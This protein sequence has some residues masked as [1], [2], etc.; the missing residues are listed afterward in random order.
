MSPFALSTHAMISCARDCGELST[1][2]GPGQS[3]A[4]HS[5]WE[6]SKG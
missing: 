5:F 3:L 4:V 2:S 1:E 6:F